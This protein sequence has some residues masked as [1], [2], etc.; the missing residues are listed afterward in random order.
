ME[1]LGKVLIPTG[2]PRLVLGSF[3]Y[4]NNICETSSLSLSLKASSGKAHIEV[5]VSLPLVLGFLWS[6]QG[7]LFHC[8]LYKI[9]LFHWRTI[10]YCRLKNMK[11]LIR[12][13]SQI[14]S[15]AEREGGGWKMLTMAEKVERGCKANA[16]NGW[17][18]GAQPSAPCILNIALPTRGSC[19]KF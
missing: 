13:C 16:D 15:A 14:M 3:I 2:I 9:H 7:V 19:F 12:G 4:H 11:K 8:T 10:F 17:Q 18:R 5:C 1:F 6:C